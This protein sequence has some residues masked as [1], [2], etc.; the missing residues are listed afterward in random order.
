MERHCGSLVEATESQENETRVTLVHGTLS[1]LLLSQKFQ[2]SSFALNAEVVNATV[3]ETCIECLWARRPELR[4]LEKYAAAH[5][6]THVSDAAFSVSLC[7]SVRELFLSNAVVRWVRIGLSSSQALEDGDDSLDVT[8]EEAPLR[9]IVAWLT[10]VEP[11]LGGKEQSRGVVEKKNEDHL[12]SWVRGVLNGDRRWQ[13]SR[14]HRAVPINTGQESPGGLLEL[15][16]RSW[17]YPA[18][19]SRL[20]KC[21]P[22]FSK[23]CRKISGEAIVLAWAHASILDE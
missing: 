1:D 21:H 16:Y 11:F 8:I 19:T 5:W 23:G 20:S 10:K 3:A 2:G 13:F 12:E 14:N 7:M 17:H 22:D 6:V 18:N 15:A 9:E 4:G